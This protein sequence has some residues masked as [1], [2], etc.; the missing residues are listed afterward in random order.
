MKSELKLDIFPHIFPQPYF[1]RMK[2]V[3]QGNPALAAT[4]KRWLGVPVLS[5]SSCFGLIL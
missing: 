3:A 1:E 4:L 5:C 2:T